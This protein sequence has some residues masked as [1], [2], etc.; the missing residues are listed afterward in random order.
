MKKFKLFEKGVELEPQNN[1]DLQKMHRIL[2]ELAKPKKKEGAIKHAKD[3]GKADKVRDA[4]VRLRIQPVPTRPKAL[5]QETRMSNLGKEITNSY[6]A[7]SFKDIDVSSMENIL[8]KAE[9]FMKKGG[10]GCIKAAKIGEWLVKWG[11]ATEAM[12]IVEMVR[13][14]ADHVA[15]SPARLIGISFAEEGHP[16]KALDAVRIM[17]E[18]VSRPQIIHRHAGNTLKVLAEKGN[19][20]EVL[21]LGKIVLNMKPWQGHKGSRAGG[22]R[23]T[24]KEILVDTGKILAKNNPENAL[25]FAKML[26]NSENSDGVSAGAAIKKLVPT[27]FKSTRDGKY[28]KFVKEYFYLETHMVGEPDKKISVLQPNAVK[29]L[30]YLLEQLE[31]KK[32]PLTVNDKNNIVEMGNLL[33][34]IAKKKPDNT[35]KY[36]DTFFAKMAKGHIKHSKF[37][38]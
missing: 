3:M 10:V 7:D 35:A 9:T 11:F 23:V 17:K 32:M 19:I 36:T 38:T 2:G 29:R 14:R 27:K 6:L 28:D 20:K 26:I 12:K 5:D 37:T 13:D 34:A 25:T 8:K 22:G 30:E 31:L 18:R 24:L 33:R 15:S 21:E 1:K 16:K 4:Q